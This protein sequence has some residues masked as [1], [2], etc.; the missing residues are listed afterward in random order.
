[1][2]KQSFLPQNEQEQLL[3]RRVGD[4]VRLAQ[5]RPGAQFTA[6]LDERQQALARQGLAGCG[7]DAY[8]FEGGFAQAERKMLAVF[9]DSGWMQAPCFPIVPLVF[10][11]R[12][13]DTLTHRDFLG[14]LMALQITREQVGDILVGEGVAVA[15]LTEPAARLARAEIGQVGRVGVR[16]EDELPDPLPGGQAFEP[17]SGTVSSLR[18]DCLVAL[19]TRLSREKAAGLIL[20]GLVS[21]NGVPVGSAADLVA[22]G[23]KL[24]IRGQG[25]FILSQV[26]ELSKKGRIHV[27]CQKYR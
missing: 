16:L 21:C 22:Q 27:T 7:W 8:Q 5:R 11:Y 14:S 10:R 6:F 9:S 26:G 3:L 13:Q 1:M 12:R 15:F 20:A 2:A 17:I 4:L 23:D 24:S 25:R 19:C 18:A